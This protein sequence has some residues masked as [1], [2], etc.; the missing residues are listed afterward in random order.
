[1]NLYNSA[2]GNRDFDT[3]LN[4]CLD[5]AVFRCRCDVMIVHFSAVFD[6]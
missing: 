6:G 2:D 1:M 5:A 4:H 3:P